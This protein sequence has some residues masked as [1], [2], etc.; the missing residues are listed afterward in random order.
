MFEYRITKYDPARRNAAGHYLVDEWISFSDIGR[1]FSGCV[2]T[3][4]D[5]Q[6]IESAYVS[7]AQAFL[8]QAGVSRLVVR[9]AE[10]PPPGIANGD[11]L[12]VTQLGEVLRRLLREEFWC[13]LEGSSAFI[14]VGYDYYMYVGVP[15][16]CINAERVTTR[17][18]LFPERFVS[19][20]HPEPEDG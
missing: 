19:P 16:R 14:H 4:D 20:Y 3:L 2:L 6:R 1:S 9:D 12:D 13:R 7:S 15:V 11:I 17:L 10:H 8:Q 5:Y 18:G